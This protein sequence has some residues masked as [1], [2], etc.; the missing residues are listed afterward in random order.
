[1]PA[2]MVGMGMSAEEKFWSRVDRSGE[3]WEWRG[4]R[5]RYGYGQFTMDGKNCR[6]HRVAYKLTYGEL[7]DSVKLDHECNNRGCVHPLHLRPMGQRENVLRSVT[8]PVAVN[9]RKTHCNRGHEFTPENT[10]IESG[11]RFCRT[12]RRARKS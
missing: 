6:A 4:G 7:A 12:C 2:N 3:C 8:N 5:D 11:W 9:A 10:G 1:M